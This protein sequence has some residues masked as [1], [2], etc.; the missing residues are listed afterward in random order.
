MGTIFKM[1][2]LTQDQK[3]YSESQQSFSADEVSG[4][5][6]LLNIFD[7]EIELLER[8]ISA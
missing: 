4:R 5:Q 7:S 6:E 8:K 1:I 3:S 2:K